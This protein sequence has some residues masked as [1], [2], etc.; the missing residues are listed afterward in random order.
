M[1]ILLDI[2]LQDY[3]DEFAVISTADAVQVV[4]K[5]VRSEQPAQYAQWA[6]R[7]GAFGET[8]PSIVATAYA[9]RVVVDGALR[10]VIQR[11]T[12]AGTARDFDAV[13]RRAVFVYP[14]VAFP[15]PTNAIRDVFACVL[16]RCARGDAHAEHRV[17]LALRAGGDADAVVTIVL[18]CVPADVLAVVR[19]I[20]DGSCSPTCAVDIDSALLRLINCDPV[21]RNL[22]RLMT[23]S[24][25]PSTELSGLMTDRA[26]VGPVLDA[27]CRR[28]TIVVEA[29]ETRC[30]FQVAAS[31]DILR[32]A[33]TLPAGAKRC[34][35]LCDNMRLI[36]GCESV[37][38]LPPPPRRPRLTPPLPRAAAKPTAARPRAASAGG[39]GGKRPR[40]AVEAA[41]PPVPAH[42]YRPAAPDAEPVDDDDTG[43]TTAEAAVHTTSSDKGATEEEKEYTAGLSGM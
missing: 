39:T 33:L 18:E 4:L 15:C 25:T 14:D 21:Y 38:R 16:Q 34:S 32:T 23:R 43:A 7:Y 31:L 27:F 8:W 2:V 12:A 3:L 6:T 42:D 11:I 35:A 13:V 19:T 26:F 10:E 22:H 37:S 5:D 1:P 20:F 41:A 9:N 29:F 28:L 40:R 17:A 24:T 30:G 36:I